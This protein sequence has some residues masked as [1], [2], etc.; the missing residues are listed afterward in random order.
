M[1]LY[2]AHCHLHGELQHTVVVNGTCPEDWPTVLGLSNQNAQIIPAIGLHPW[3]VNDAPSD[4]QTSFLNYIDAA[5]A[6]GEIGLDQWVDDY[7]IERQQAAFIW[8]LEQAAIRNLPVSIHC[9]KASAPLLQTLRTQTYPARGIHLHAFSGSAEQVSQLAELGA[10]FS[11]HAGQLSGNAKKAPAAVQAVPADRM[12][13][14]TDAPGTLTESIGDT[15]FLLDGYQRAAE[16]RGVAVEA[17][18]EQ[19]AANFTRYFLND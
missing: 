2:D 8:Q 3:Q 1:K 4:W 12:L 14:E 5:K 19:V 6:V 10:Y 15:A 16:L 18:A 17:L 7:D 9:L 13:I 11:F